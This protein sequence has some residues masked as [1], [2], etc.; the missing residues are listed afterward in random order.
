MDS[1]VTSKFYQYMSV[2]ETWIP[3]YMDK[4]SYAQ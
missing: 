2:Q 4:L 1:Y 3:F